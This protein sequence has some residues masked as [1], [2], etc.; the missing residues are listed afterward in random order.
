MITTLFLSLYA[1][2]LGLISQMMGNI[3]GSIPESTLTQITTTISSIGTKLNLVYN[4]IPAADSLILV[5]QTSITL[6]LG[7]LA[8]RTIVFIINEFRGSGGTV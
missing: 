2:F 5:I 4:L 7:Y 3:A 6:V 1:A 8:L